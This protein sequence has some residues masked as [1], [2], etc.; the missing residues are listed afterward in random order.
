M[1]SFNFRSFVRACCAGLRALAS[2]Y[3]GAWLAKKA[4]ALDV[5]FE[6]APEEQE[7]FALIVE[8][9]DAAY[10]AESYSDSPDTAAD[11][12]KHW[13]DRG[14]K[15]GRQIARSVI[16]RY[17]KVARRSSSSNW[18][19]YK[20]RGE[21][22]A[23]RFSP[24]IPQQILS[25]ILNQVRHEP[26]L[27][28]PGAKTIANLVR[29]ERESDSFIDVAGL[30]RAIAQRTEILVIVP[31]FNS[32]PSQ[33][34]VVD[35]VA[36]LAQAGLGSIRTIITD[37]ESTG[38]SDDFV[39]APF[40]TTNPIYWQDF[41]IRGPETVRMAKL[42]YLVGLLLP[43]ITIVA[44]SSHGYETVTRFGPGLS[45]RTKIYSVFEGSERGS[46]LA[47][48]FA[49]DLLPV[50]TVLTDGVALAARLREQ[51]DGLPGYGIEF[52]PDH[53]SAAFVACVTRLFQ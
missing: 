26:A 14:V 41:W 52:L 33:V 30:Q 42:A 3:R 45:Q 37:R 53:P 50:S 43:R 13:L 31:D 21:D 27:L 7:F 4:S 2:A 46:E 19:H 9:F 22:V 38:N 1:A 17:G 10:Y 8:H 29:L 47:A 23:A 16:L 49:R 36:A 18:K 40:K 32:S 25:Q 5:G 15:E 51:H 28:A 44:D 20:W 48:R 34:L 11:A 24:P 39:P 6:V 35:L 12:L